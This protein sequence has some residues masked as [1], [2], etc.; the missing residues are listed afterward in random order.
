MS[1][2]STRKTVNGV[3]WLGTQA[4]GLGLVLFSAPAVF[5]PRFFGRLAGLPVADDAAATVAVRSVAVRDVVMG[6]GLVSA[7]RH[8]SRLAPW[9]LIRTLCDGGD[10]AGIGLA[11]LRGGGNRRLGWLGIIALAATAYDLWLYFVAKGEET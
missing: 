8:H 1:G 5:A 3:L 10:A 2:M 9:L 11:F 6:V 4:L 7:A